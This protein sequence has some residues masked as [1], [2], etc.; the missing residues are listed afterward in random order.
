MEIDENGPALPTK[1]GHLDHNNSFTLSVAQARA[2]A[3][4]WLLASLSLL[5]ERERGMVVR[6]QDGWMLPAPP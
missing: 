1:G 4:A 6:Q 3:L 2:L 5:E